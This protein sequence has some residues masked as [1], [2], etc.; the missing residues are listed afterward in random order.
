VS[1]HVVTGVEVHFAEHVVV[2]AT[3]VHC[4]AHPPPVTK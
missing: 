2:Y 3:G 1:V 4:E